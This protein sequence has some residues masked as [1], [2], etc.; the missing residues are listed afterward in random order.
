MV[1]PPLALPSSLSEAFFFVFLVFVF[2]YQV[3]TCFVLFCS[4]LRVVAFRCV[5]RGFWALRHRVWRAAAAAAAAAVPS[6]VSAA[7]PAV[8]ATAATVEKASTYVA[9]AVEYAAGLV[10]TLGYSSFQ[11]CQWGFQWWGR[12][13]AA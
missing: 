9:A 1:G 11:R 4:G 2:I 7:A 8:A 13:H 10:L 3:F 12:G 5:G 6:A